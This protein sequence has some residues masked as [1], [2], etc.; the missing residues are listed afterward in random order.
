MEVGRKKEV[1]FY[2][3]AEAMDKLRAHAHTICL[4]ETIV[5][6]LKQLITFRDN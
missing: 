6:N 3:K 2:R 4:Q 5:T 1:G